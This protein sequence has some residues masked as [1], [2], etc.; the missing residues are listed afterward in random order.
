MFE[1]R[2]RSAEGTNQSV[3]QTL[4]I[5]P[6]PILS[7]FSFPTRS[8]LKTTFAT[9]DILSFN[10]PDN[11]NMPFKTQLLD[12]GMEFFQRLGSLSAVVGGAMVVGGSLLIG[13]SMVEQTLG[14]I[15][16]GAGL[17]ALGGIAAGSFW[18]MAR[19]FYSLRQ[20]NNVNSSTRD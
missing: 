16:F 8:E 5:P 19:H 4:E 6:N 12:I 7:R 1:S 18:S 20:R 10:H 17:V 14:G 15:G 2:N 11:K 9:L 3:A 13:T